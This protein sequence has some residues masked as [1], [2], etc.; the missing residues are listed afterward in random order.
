MRTL[1]FSISLLAILALGCGEQPVT[2]SGDGTAATAKDSVADAGMPFEEV[3]AESLKSTLANNK[4][5]LIEFTAD[6]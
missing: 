4:V 2:D 6:W 1:L 5:T 3:N